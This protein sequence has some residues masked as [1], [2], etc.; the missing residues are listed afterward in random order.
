MNK[1]AIVKIFE[2]Y[3]SALFNYALRLCGDPMLADH[4]VGDVFAKLLDQLAAGKGPKSNLRA[5]LYE[6]AYHR[7]IDDARY[8]KRRVPLEVTAWL[9]QDADS[10]SVRLKD[11]I[12]LKQITHALKHDLTDDQRHV[13]ILRFVE[14]FSLR[15]TALIMGKPVDHVK[16]IQS[17]AIAALRRSL[18]Y[19]E[20]QKPASHPRIRHLSKAF[21]M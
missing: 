6:T 21:G 13:V 10:A 5:Y 12:L 1:D 16:V 18:E 14:D 2:L 20:I 15:E 7:I 11:P 4:V 3:S 19:R 8:S 9:Q 17:R